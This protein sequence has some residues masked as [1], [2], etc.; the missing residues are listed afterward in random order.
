[1][2]QWVHRLY[3]VDLTTRT[4]ICLECGPTNLKITLRNGKQKPTCMKSYKRH[5]TPYKR[6]KKAICEQCG[7]V[8]T[9][10]S[11]L[12]VDHIDG[13]RKNN[14]LSNLKT[15]CANCHRL[16]TAIYKEWNNKKAP[17]ANG[18]EG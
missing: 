15:L 9:H 4:A 17:T 18:D 6:F 7:F 1:M 14:D 10:I 3:D 13:N 5:K 2:A 12:D 11:Q 16:K 8:P